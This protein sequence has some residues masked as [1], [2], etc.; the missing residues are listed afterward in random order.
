[1][2]DGGHSTRLPAD[3]ESNGVNADG[4]NGITRM[5]LREWHY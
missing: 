5:A 1:M 2:R 3:G 4:V